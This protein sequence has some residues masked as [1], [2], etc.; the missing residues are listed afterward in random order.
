MAIPACCSH[1]RSGTNGQGSDLFEVEGSALHLVGHTGPC[2]CPHGG[3]FES[4]QGSAI[5]EVE[6]RPVTLIGHQTVCQNCGKS[7]AHS[8]GTELLEV[9]V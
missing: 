6:G 5:I 9:E 7:G 1:S 4:V 8:S 2:N 3:T